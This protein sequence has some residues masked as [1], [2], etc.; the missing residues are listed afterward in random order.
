RAFYIQD[1]WEPFD[2][3]TLSLGLRRDDFSLSKG[4]GS[5]LVDL[6]E[7]YAPRIGAS[8]ELWPDRSGKV[9]A[10]YG[11]YFLPIASNTAFRQASPE[12]YFRER[13][14]YTGF[15]SDGLPILGTQITT[16]DAYQSACPFGLTP[17][18]SGANCAVTGSGLVPDTTAA[19]SHDLK[20][21]KESEWILGYEHRLG[22]WTIGLTYTHRNMDR[23]AEDMAIDRAVLN[24]CDDNG[25]AGCDATWTG[26]H[27]Y[28]IANPGQDLTINLAGLDGQLVTFTAEELAAIGFP[29]ATRK[30]DAVDLTFRRPWDGKWAFE[31]NYTWSKSR[32]NSEGFVQSDF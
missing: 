6:D 26:F 27:Q 8:Y 13:F 1:E 4:D 28:V 30:Y 24:Y 11:H 22:D 5:P 21:T 23:S 16:L 3:L 9:R 17:G 12:L 10:F 29:K 19:I 7:N 2:R 32:G 25:I 20:A 15:D 31:G 14:N 18:S